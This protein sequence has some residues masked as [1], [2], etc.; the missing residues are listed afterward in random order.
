M[1]G[2]MGQVARHRP[3]RSVSGVAAVAVQQQ[4][5]QITTGE[6]CVSNTLPSFTER[7]LLDVHEPHAFESHQVW[8]LSS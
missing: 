5:W 8:H 7:A 6:V 2:S 3:P 1:W 4:A